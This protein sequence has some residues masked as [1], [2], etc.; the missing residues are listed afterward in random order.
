[1][2]DERY[3]QLIEMHR[4]TKRRLDTIQT[5]LA[6]VLVL[7]IIPPIMKQMGWWNLLGIG[8]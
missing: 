8:E 2:D 7:I 5:M 3:R 6:L 1:M 4:A